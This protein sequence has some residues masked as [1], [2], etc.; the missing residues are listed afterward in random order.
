MAGLGHAEA[1]RVV[2]TAIAIAI[3]G[4]FVIRHQV[5]R[6]GIMPD[7]VR[8]NFQFPLQLMLEPWAVRTLPPN[9]RLPRP[10]WQQ[11]P[12]YH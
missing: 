11:S 1:R 10:V 9:H 5:L 3:Q 2:L 8:V 7:T 6:D 12:D 4:L